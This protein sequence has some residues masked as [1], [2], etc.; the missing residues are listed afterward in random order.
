M[1]IIR[2]NS[3]CIH[4]INGRSRLKVVPVVTVPDPFTKGRLARVFRVEQVMQESPTN[5][6]APGEEIALS[7]APENYN[8]KEY[9]WKRGEPCQIKMKARPGRK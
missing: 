5:P 4:L 2:H 7:Y 6:I 3:D 1:K 9:E 8:R